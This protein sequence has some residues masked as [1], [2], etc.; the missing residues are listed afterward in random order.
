MSEPATSFYEDFLTAK[1]EIK[2]IIKDKAVHGKNISYSYVQLETILEIVNPILAAH[3]LFLTQDVSTTDNSVSVQTTLYSTSG[4]HLSS[5]HLTFPHVDSNNAQQYGTQITYM[6][7]YQLVAFL[8]IP[9]ND[10]DTD[11]V[12]P[13]PSASGAY[14]NPEAVQVFQRLESVQLPTNQWADFLL[15]ATGHP[16]ANR[17]QLGSGEA[18]KILKDFDLYYRRFTAPKQP[19]PEIAQF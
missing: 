16:V 8:A 18:K 5:G 4:E 12:P 11:G 13:T 10:P 1:S 14:V 7:R 9:V 6:R 15:S 19:Q 3:H 2:N 17:Q